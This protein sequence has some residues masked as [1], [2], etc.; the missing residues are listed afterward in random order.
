MP[1]SSYATLTRVTPAMFN[2]KLESVDLGDSVV[3]ADGLTTPAP[4]FVHVFEITSAGGD[5][6][7]LLD[8]QE[9]IIRAWAVK[10]GAGGAGDTI[11]LFNDTDA[12]TEALS[13]NVADGIV[14]NFAKILPAF[15]DVLA[16]GTL[17]ATGVNAHDCACTVFVEVLRTA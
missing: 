15:A 11:Q 17:K 1:G 7:I 2:A 10:L 6:S 3:A 8:K 5:N 12:I 13:L 9:R 14:A 4:S 16:A